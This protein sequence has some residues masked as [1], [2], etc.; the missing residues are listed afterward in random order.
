MKNYKTSNLVI[1]NICLLIPLILYG[2]FKNGYLVYEKGLINFVDIFKPLYLVI[3]GVIIKIIIDVIRYKKIKIDYNFIYVILVGMI[4]PNNINLLI[5]L[6]NFIILYILALFLEKYFRFNKVCFIYLIIILINFIFNDFSFKSIL[7]E[8]YSFSFSFLDLLMGR[9]IGGIS[10]TSIIFSLLGYIIL[11]SNF[12]YKKDIPL[13]IN[14]IYLLLSIIYFINTNDNSIL[15][16]SDLIFASIFISSLPEY[17]PYKNVNQ[18]IYG[19]LIGIFSFVLAITFN[20]IISVYIATFIVSLFQNIKLRKKK[21][22][23]SILE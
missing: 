15:L 16:N 3:I 7:E 1:Q 8:N 17:S 12:Y 20:N 9:S 6:I 14:L 5:Y 10:S 13:T 11:I 18:I 21:V 22:K 23:L 19:I 2:I 4:M